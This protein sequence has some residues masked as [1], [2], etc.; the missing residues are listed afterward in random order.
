MIGI[1]FAIVSLLTFNVCGVDGYMHF[2][3]NYG[4]DTL[5]EYVLVVLMLCAVILF[6]WALFVT[7]PIA[8]RPVP[9]AYVPSISHVAPQTCSFARTFAP[10]VSVVHHVAAPVCTSSFPTTVHRR[11]VVTSSTPTSYPSSFATVSP[12]AP[13]TQQNASYVATGYGDTEER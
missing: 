7:M 2:V 9:V 11:T 1:V 10:S 12:P 8:P 13:S 5:I 4:I 3:P 6:F